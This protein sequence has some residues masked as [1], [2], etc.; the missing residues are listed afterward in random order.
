M[1][2]FL[3]ILVSV[4]LASANFWLAYVPAGERNRLLIISTSI[5]IFVL[6]LFIKLALK[7][8]PVFNFAVLP[9]SLVLGFSSLA[10]FFP[11]LNFSFRLMLWAIGS[12]IFYVCL[13]SLNVFAVVLEREV[14][15]PLLRAAITVS[16]LVVSASLFFIF[17]AIYKIEAIF[18]V[19]GILVFVSC[20]LLN[21]FYFWAGSL[22]KH[23]LSFDKEAFLSA[24]VV[25]EV[26]VATA[27]LPLES[28]FRGFLLISLVYVINGLL[29]A[30][31]KHALNRRVVGE[32]VLVLVFVVLLLMAFNF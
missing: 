19:Q 28:F 1:K 20:Y 4:L 32:Y 25:F 16:S 10:I 6:V 23:Y 29:L 21:R 17:T 26:A 27:F 18:A 9:V 15:V 14:N 8:V 3:F 22:E 2:R 5:F 7:K 30:R 11:N 24:L 13:L 31:L 12:L